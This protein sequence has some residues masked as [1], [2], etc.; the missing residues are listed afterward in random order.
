MHYFHFTW[1]SF[2]QAL[3][4]SNVPYIFLSW[5]EHS[6]QFCKGTF[7]F[8]SFE[9]NR[10]S[11]NE[12]KLHSETIFQMNTA[13]EIETGSDQFY[14]FYANKNHKFISFLRNSEW[15]FSLFLTYGWIGCCTVVRWI[16]FCESPIQE[17]MWTSMECHQTTDIS[18]VVSRLTNVTRYF[19]WAIFQHKCFHPL[20][21]IQCVYVSR[22]LW[23]KVRSH[24][25][26]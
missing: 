8:F 16:H 1:L 3:T 6:R 21:G 26:I 5:Q 17:F 13:L 14:T 9:H 22:L 18:I 12:F 24:C 11:N 25:T 23:H 20:Y 4:F 19:L 15:N 7:H 10:W 2:P